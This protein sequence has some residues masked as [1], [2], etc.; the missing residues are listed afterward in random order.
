MLNLQFIL[1]AS[2]H[3]NVFDWYI[4]NTKQTHAKSFV[5]GVVKL[6]SMWHLNSMPLILKMR[7]SLDQTVIYL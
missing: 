1:R 2:W 4:Q 3:E 6:W 7:V 5:V